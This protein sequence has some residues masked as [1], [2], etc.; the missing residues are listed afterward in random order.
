MEKKSKRIKWNEKLNKYLMQPRVRTVRM[1]PSSLNLRFFLVTSIDIKTGV[2]WGKSFTAFVTLIPIREALDLE[3]SVENFPKPSL[4][5][6]VQYSTC[7]IEGSLWYKTAPSHGES[8]SPGSSWS[9]QSF[10]TPFSSPKKLVLEFV[11]FA[12]INFKVLGNFFLWSTVTVLLVK[13][14]FHAV[15][16]GRKV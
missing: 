13:H 4:S 14:S 11:H 7:V 1:I 10:A 9:I 6:V 5:K 15:L 3:T 8:M 16:Q 2:P 12:G